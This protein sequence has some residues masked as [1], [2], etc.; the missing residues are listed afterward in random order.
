[1]S[2]TIKKQFYVAPKNITN[3]LKACIDS[4]EAVL[5]I[6]ETGTGKTTIIRELGKEHGK[7]VL[8][9][10]LNGTTGIDEILGKWLAK[11]GQTVWQDGVLIQAM[12]LGNWIV[13]DEINAALPEILFALHSL[14]DDDRHVILSEKDG[15]IVRPNEEFRFFATMNPPEDYA[16]T[17]DLNKALLSR[18]A[19][20]MEVPVLGEAD[21]VSV[22]SEIHGI[23][24]PIA[25]QLV[26]IGNMLRNKK[27]SDEIFYFC[28]TRDL[29]SAGK[30][31]GKGLAISNAVQASILGKMTKN[32]LEN[33]AKDLSHLIT[34]PAPTVGIAEMQIQ[35]ESL[36]MENKSL[37]ANNEALEGTIKNI[38]DNILT[39]LQEVISGKK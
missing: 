23:Q 3:T 30:L 11:N 39:R 33:V 4:Q 8:R 28:S 19:A 17:K 16:G 18:F 10:S 6:G 9:I 12:K 36:T 25:M 38:N 27:K 34:K 31:V 37:K 1:M 15:E 20:V 35:I 32:E 21:E 2:K 14:L 29:V 24:E 26:T 5:L 22:L 7:E 13:F